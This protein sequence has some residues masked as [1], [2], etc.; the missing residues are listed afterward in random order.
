MSLYKTVYP[1]RNSVHF[2]CI[3]KVQN[4]PEIVGLVASEAS[5]VFAYRSEGRVKGVEGAYKSKIQKQHL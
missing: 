5:C 4:D 2:S 3:F 1:S